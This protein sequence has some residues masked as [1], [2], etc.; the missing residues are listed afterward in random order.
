MYYDT[1]NAGKDKTQYKQRAAKQDERI[2]Q[3]LINSGLDDRCLGATEIW[4]AVF[5]NENV[6]ITSVR[7]ALNTLAKKG[8]VKKTNTFAIGDY[9]RPEHGWTLV[10][11]DQRQAELF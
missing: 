8:H 2:L 1:A 4:K 6:P 3:F 5:K 9:G 10:K 7:R 11:R